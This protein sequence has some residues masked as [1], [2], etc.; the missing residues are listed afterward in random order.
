M[1][2]IVG[3]CA[4]L[5]LGQRRKTMLNTATPAIQPEDRTIKRLDQIDAQSLLSAGLN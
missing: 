5:A 3:A 1:P 2:V 4:Q